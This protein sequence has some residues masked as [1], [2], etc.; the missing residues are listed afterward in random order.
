[1]YDHFAVRCTHPLVAVPGAWAYDNPQ[2]EICLSRHPRTMSK[3]DAQYV[4]D[5]IEERGPA[6]HDWLPVNEWSATICI[7]TFAIVHAP[8]DPTSPT[9]L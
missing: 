3:I 4:A 1:M 2:E 6:A 5:A 9:R 8:D 7:A